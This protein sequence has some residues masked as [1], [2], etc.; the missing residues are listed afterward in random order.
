MNQQVNIIFLHRSIGKDILRG[1]TSRVSYK[2]F[3]YGSVQQWFSKFNKANKT[4]YQLE[5][6]YFP[7]LNEE[8][9]SG[10][11]PYDYYN[12]WVK[13][14]QGKDYM[15][16]PT[17][18]SLTEKYDVVVWKHC[19]PVSEIMT[20]DAPG[21]VNSPERRVENYMLQYAQ[22]KEK[23]KSFPRTKFIV[24]TGAALPKSSTTPEAAQRVRDFFNWVKEQWDEPGDNIFLWDFYELQTE[25]GL[26]LK[27]EYSLDGK[28]PHPSRAL[29]A[30]A[31]PLFCKRIVDVIE[32][33]GDSSAK[34]GK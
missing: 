14:G 5:T 17:L 10:N 11:F 15:K 33:R 6:M 12:I 4:N 18:E 8:Y 27:D 16:E 24:W 7:Q 21:D 34:T 32:G 1:E 23:M 25:G 3:K 13:N 30:L 29:A 28:D 22:L 20:N 2:I 26:Y 31:A 19:F 9:G